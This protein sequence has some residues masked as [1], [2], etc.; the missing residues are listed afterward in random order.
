VLGRTSEKGGKKG[1]GHW[2]K[3]EGRVFIVHSIN[4]SFSCR[5]E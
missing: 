4:G 1:T 3:R 2:G 5:E